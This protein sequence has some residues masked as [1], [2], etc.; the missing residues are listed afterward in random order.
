MI[1]YALVFVFT[2]GYG[3][4]DDP[5]D[6]APKAAYEACVREA[7]SVVKPADAFDSMAQRYVKIED[8]LAKRGFKK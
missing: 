2:L 3:L 1:F 6:Y 7:E 8:C 4:A 5:F